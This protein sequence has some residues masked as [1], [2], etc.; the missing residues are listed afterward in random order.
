MELIQEFEVGSI[1]AKSTNVHE[2][3]EE[4]LTEE[5]RGLQLW[6]QEVLEDHPALSILPEHVKGGL[7]VP[8]GN[9]KDLPANRHQ[10][11]RLQREGYTLHFF[12]GEAE[13]FGLHKAF[14]EAGVGKRLLEVDLKR[15]E[16]YDMLGDTLYP[17]LLRAAISGHLLGVIGG[18]NCRTR[19][20]LRHY[21]KQGA[22]RP[23]RSWQDGQEY[24]LFKLADH[25]RKALHDDDLM[26]WRMLHAVHLCDR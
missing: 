2:S 13:G 16:S 5:D 14:K 3:P 4:S 26:L 6:M 8:L 23:I 12:A 1:K 22:P 20:V 9:L 17:A 24:G 10:R 7:V 19:S 18:P 11:K 15:G 21:P 25:E